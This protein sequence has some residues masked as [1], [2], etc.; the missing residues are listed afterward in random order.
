MFLLLSQSNPYFEER[1]NN[2]NNQMAHKD[3]EGI[4]IDLKDRFKEQDKII[5][6]HH[7]DDMSLET[8]EELISSAEEDESG[9][10]SSQNNSSSLISLNSENK[11]NKKL[12]EKKSITLKKEDQLKMYRQTRMD[13]FKLLIKIFDLV[14][15]L[16]MI[17][18]HVLSQIE[19]EEF[20]LYNREV[21]IAGSILYNYLYRSDNETITWN[22]VFD[23]SRLN[24]KKIFFLCLENENET[25]H[26]KYPKKISDYMGSKGITN[27]H[28]M[29]NFQ[30]LEAYSISEATF[31]YD[32]DSREMSEGGQNQNNN[33]NDSILTLDNFNFDLNVSELSNRLRI[34]ILVLTIAAFCLFFISWY[35][36]YYLEE[37][38]DLMIG[39][40][41]KES[42]QDNEE[43]KDNNMAQNNIT[44][45]KK[46]PHFYNS[47]YFLYLILELIILAIIP[48][49]GE[50]F[51]FIVKYSKRAIIYPFSSLFN[52]IL[53]LR[54]LFILKL[55]NIY[56]LY[57]K[58]AQEKILMKNGIKPNFIFDL[59]AYHKK[60]PFY[61]LIII[62]VLIVYI[63]GNLLR[64]FEMY[65]WEGATQYRQFWNYHWNSFWCV[66]ISMTTVAFG[67]LYPSTHIGRILIIIATII[68][69]YFIFMSMTLITQKSIL[70]DTELKAYKLINR[71]RYRTLLKDVNANI[72]YHSLKMIQLR[73][74]FK[75]KD[76]N[77]Q[78]IYEMEFDLEKKA[79]LNEIENYKIFNEQLKASDKVQTK[80]QLIDILEQIEKNIYDIE[81]ELIILEKINT[82]FQGFKNTQLLMIKYL[83]SNILNTQFIYDIL[84]R[85]H[86]IYGVLGMD[87]NVAEKEK[88]KLQQEI[89][90]L[91]NNYH[92]AEKALI[93]NS[94]NNKDLNNNE[95][96]E[97]INNFFDVKRNSVKMKKKNTIYILN[98]RND[99]HA[100]KNDIFNWEKFFLPLSA[101]NLV[102]K[103]KKIKRLSNAS[104]SKI[105]RGNGSGVWS[106][107]STIIGDGRRIYPEDLYARE[108][109]K[110][111]V[112]Q[113]DFSKYFYS[114]FF[115]RNNNHN[116]NHLND[117]KNLIQNVIMRNYPKTLSSIKVMKNIKSKLDKIIQKYNESS[118]DS[119]SNS[120]DENK[121]VEN[122]E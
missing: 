8:K 81:E 68:G 119:S 65:Y 1:N 46:I 101:Q 19:D 75:K 10:D 58:P 12:K 17:I 18:T 42:K 88:H 35:L 83:K 7:F 49:P 13:R 11:I 16:I 28:E 110:Y 61:S 112:D 63:F 22:E 103:K 74:K 117:E 122:A 111:N 102:G 40:L 30:I 52:A 82:S 38:L 105:K 108:L 29:N 48:Y 100:N 56:S 86:K 91:Y 20:Y 64:Y 96:P 106:T 34:A 39:E 62:F 51:K 90:I 89:D 21:R 80:D 60:Y 24:L 43:A 66:F 50:N 33:L 37:K 53:T 78:K 5:K 85:N 44:V 118:G 14:A 45:Y 54:I 27:F 76:I 9:D 71:L 116:M 6:F 84:Q 73:K 69:I 3:L 104:V 4:E 59:K 72:I 23:D 70:S 32:L 79:I 31:G 55:I 113:N 67:D 99:S 47:I 95:N 93:K 120:M 109:Q 107:N 115:Q 41:N 92:E 87:Q 98:E 97:N 94:E 2:Q 57:R 25:L 114:V 26:K 77:N 15:I 121:E 36:Q